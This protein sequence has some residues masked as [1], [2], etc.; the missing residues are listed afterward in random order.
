LLNGKELTEEGVGFGVPVAKYEDKTYFPGSANS[1]MQ[2]EKNSVTLIKS[3]SLDIISRKRLGTG[4]FVN[5][6]LYHFLHRA[7]EMGYLNCQGLAEASNKIM[8]LR[9]VF[10]IHTE[11]VR[12]KPRGNVTCKYSCQPCAIEIEIELSLKEPNRC[13]E[14][15]IL[16][17]Q[18]S[19]F[20]R[21]Y[22]DSEGLTLHDRKIGAWTKIMA[23]EA[24][25]SDIKKTLTFTIKNKSPASLFR[26]WEK[27][28]GRFSWAGLAYSLP[29][30]KS[31]FC[32]SIE[33]SLE[34]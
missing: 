1:W 32:Y 9:K 15:V 21:R 11:F 14:I 4:T 23:G 13:K 27:T 34:E 18:G 7:F 12:V 8:E 16:N 10:K 20:F 24:S 29:P 2:T 3:Y 31:I 33:L 26:G 30:T 25:F 6:R 5:D 22:A 19:T 17:E 28:R